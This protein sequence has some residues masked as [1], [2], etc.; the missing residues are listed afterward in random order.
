[1]GRKKNKWLKKVINFYRFVFKFEVPFNILIDGNFIATMLRKKL[2][3]KEHLS[4]VLDDSVHIVITSCIVS[5]LRELNDKIPGILDSVFKYKIEECNHGG[6]TL[7][8]ENCIKTAISKRNP[9]KYFVATEDTFLRTQLRKI[10]G[11]P[12]LFFG[13]N[14]VL[15]DK[16]SKA[17][18][19]VSE[20]RE[21]LKEE[22]KKFE[23]KV[24]NEE[25]KDIREFMKEEYKHS[26]HY[27]RK[28]EDFKINKIM[29]RI[30]KKANG[31]NPLSV[32]KKQ[33][34][35]EITPRAENGDEK[36]IRKRQKKNKKIS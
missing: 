16:P 2:E 6:Q 28:T 9:K 3:L 30:R 26:L 35:N 14:M 17:S 25:R 24:L 32:K 19:E 22:P 31:P 7:T 36:K 12:L 18:L 1:M 23:K 33:N 13:Q 5:E 10:P 20:K 34:E 15:I 4:K 11:V 29:G 8:P 21:D 27:K